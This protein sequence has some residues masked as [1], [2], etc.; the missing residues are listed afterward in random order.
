MELYNMLK[1]ISG[2][3]NEEELKNSISIVK[4]QLRGL[5]KER[6]CKVYSSFLLR[7]LRKRHV[8]SRLINTLDLGLTYEHVF[9]L[10]PKNEMEG[11]LLSDLTFSQFNS[12]LDKFTQLSKNGY[13]TIDDVDLN[14]Y[15]NIISKQDLVNEFS[16]EDIFYY[17]QPSNIN[18]LGK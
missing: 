7:E 9:V 4:Q 1:N 13:Q 11:Y 2:K 3:N 17:Q 8:P 18:S 5:T 6:M 12:E 10:V 16:L 14:Y 15:L